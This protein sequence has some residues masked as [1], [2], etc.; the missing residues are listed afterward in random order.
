M[1][2]GALAHTGKQPGTLATVNVVADQCAARSTSPGASR[3]PCRT[4]ITNTIDGNGGVVGAIAFITD[5]PK[6]ADATRASS[7]P[8]APPSKP[9]TLRPDRARAPLD[10]RG[11]NWPTD[12]CALLH[13][14]SPQELGSNKQDDHDNDDQ[15]DEVAS[16]AALGQGLEVGHCRSQH[17]T[18]AVKAC[19]HRVEHRVLGIDL[20]TDLNSHLGGGT[21]WSGEAQRSRTKS[22]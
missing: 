4:I 1:P 19:A 15:D 14:C 11:D 12:G 22:T 8:A 2:R 6:A 7:S 3:R 10:G 20:C 9:A 5:R 13:P 16:A 17:T 18:G 21:R